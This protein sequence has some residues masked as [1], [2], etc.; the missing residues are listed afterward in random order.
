MILALAQSIGTQSCEFFPVRLGIL[1]YSARSP[2]LCTARLCLASTTCVG[3]HAT[4]LEV[5][6]VMAS[7]GLGA[8]SAG[9][10]S[11]PVGLGP[12][13]RPGGLTL[14][15]LESFS[16]C[17]GLQGLL[18][19]LTAF[20]GLL[21]IGIERF[22]SRAYTTRSCAHTLLGTSICDQSAFRCGAETVL[23]ASLQPSRYVPACCRGASSAYGCSNRCITN[24]LLRQLSR[25]L[26]LCSTF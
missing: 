2:K 19:G 21:N 18:G 13:L 17:L 16:A 15:P 9:P 3:G 20:A 14:R 1:R 12:H 24:A 4:P 5:G 8:S 23:V 6:P 7:G 11:F 22:W 10:G 26:T 25:G